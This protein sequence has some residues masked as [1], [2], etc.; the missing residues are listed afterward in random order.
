MSK[1]ELQQK[2]K[3]LQAGAI[4]LKFSVAQNQRELQTKNQQI[5][6][7]QAQLAALENPAEIVVSDHAIVRYL[8]RIKG[9]D[10]NE[11]R[12]AILN[13]KIMKCISVVGANG[14]FPHEDG[15]KIIFKKNIAV[16]IIEK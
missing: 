8:E 6:E 14:T 11:V 10:M 4:I 15:F 3:N 7:L 9:V 12:Q 2:I 1:K 5:A 16:T 13:P